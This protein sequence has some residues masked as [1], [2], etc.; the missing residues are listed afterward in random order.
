MTWWQWPLGLLA[1][2]LLVGWILALTEAAMAFEDERAEIEKYE[3]PGD[4]EGHL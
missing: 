1:F 2:A 3:D 4:D